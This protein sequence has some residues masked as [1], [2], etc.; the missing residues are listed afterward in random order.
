ML[1]GHDSSKM[2]NK[3]PNI[4]KKGILGEL[5]NVQPKLS[6]DLMEHKNIIKECKFIKNSKGEGIKPLSI[7]KGNPRVPLNLVL[8]YYA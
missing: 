7:P 4:K 6:K 8:F 1:T 5:N 3:K 2:L